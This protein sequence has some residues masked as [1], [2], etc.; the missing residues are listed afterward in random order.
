MTSGRLMYAVGTMWRMMPAILGCALLLIGCRDAGDVEQ[1]GQGVSEPVVRT[2]DRGPVKLT[3]TA[4]KSEISIAE[5]LQLTI[6]VN[7]EEGIEVEM[8]DFG[9]SLAE[10]Q[11]RDFQEKPA[12]VGDDGRQT[13]EQSY[14]LDIFLSG[15][16]TIP[17]ITAKY[18]KDAEAIGEPAEEAPFAEL[19]SEPITIKVKSLLEGEFDPQKFHGVKPVAELRADWA[20][21]TIAATAGGGLAGLIVVILLIVWLVRRLTRPAGEVRVPPH[22]WALEQLRVL[23]AEQLVERG[24]V[25]E[26]YYRLSEIARRYI[27][28]RFGLMAPERTTEEFL[29]EMRQSTALSR[30]HQAALGDFLEACDLVKYA[31]HEPTTA[32]I[33]QVFNTARD[34]VLETRPTAQPETA[35]AGVPQEAAA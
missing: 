14:D 34:F 24:R 18:R 35:G 16:Y 4:D 31:R 26:F 29:L 23:A 28:L 7:A 30:T 27:E 3:V 17:G 20:W 12:Q 22:E 6:A 25:Q 2:V 8:P 21:G 33:E 13:F 5:R 11:I 9:A 10:F 15:E 19:T 1:A 32:E